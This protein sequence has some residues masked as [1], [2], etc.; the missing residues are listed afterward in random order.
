MKPKSQDTKIE[1]RMTFQEKDDILQKV[2]LYGFTSLSEYIRV[3][4]VKGELK[5]K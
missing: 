4:A 3:I 5:I 1:V 2:K